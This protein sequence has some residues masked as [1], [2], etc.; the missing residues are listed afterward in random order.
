M[1]NYRVITQ[2]NLTREEA[3]TIRLSIQ[4]DFSKIAYIDEVE[5]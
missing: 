3:E 2:G 5:D 1:T 4:R